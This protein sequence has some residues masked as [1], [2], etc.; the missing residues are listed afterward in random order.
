M[1]PSLIEPLFF[2]KAAGRTVTLEM[3]RRR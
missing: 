2:V 1:E 3:D